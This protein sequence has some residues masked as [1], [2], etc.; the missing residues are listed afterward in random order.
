MSVQNE[1]CVLGTEASDTIFGNTKIKREIMKNSIF[2]IDPQSYKNLAIYDYNL[3]SGMDFKIRYYGCKYYDGPELPGNIIFTPV[4]RYNKMNSN[5]KKALSYML[6]YIVIFVHILRFRP[7]IIHLQWLKLETVDYLFYSFLRLL[8]IKIVFTAH[9]VLPHNTGDRYAGIYKKIYNMANAVIVHASDTK[10]KI[11]KEFGIPRDKIHIIN[12]GLLRLK[13]D[14]DKYNALKV[15]FDKKYNF[16]NKITFTSLGEQSTYKGIDTLIKIW[17]ETPELYNN[18]NIQLVMAG[19]V[20][21]LDMS[22]LRGRNNVVIKDMRI[23]DE[24]FYYLLTHTDV[25]LLPYREISQSGAMFTALSYHVPILVTDKGGLTA[26]LSMA[27][28]GWRIKEC[29]YDLLKNMLISLSHNRHEIE[30]VKHNMPAWKK[31]E[32]A[33]DWH[34]IAKQTIELYGRIGR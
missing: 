3:L 17:T 18:S 20:K 24:E 4:F 31:I 27:K 32:E 13:I 23:S 33:Y 11:E 8:G 15:K 28:V 29:N 12:H 10:S 25:Y 26:P 14:T 22:Q 5:I 1:D 16:D 30:S 9:N 7:R 2:Y 34:T 19:K 21:D 6:S